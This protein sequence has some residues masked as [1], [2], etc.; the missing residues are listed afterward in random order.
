MLIFGSVLCLSG[1]QE[2]E[3]VVNADVTM[4]CGVSFC[5]ARVGL[6]IA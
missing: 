5:N 2:R 6:G 1:D 4:K 3:F